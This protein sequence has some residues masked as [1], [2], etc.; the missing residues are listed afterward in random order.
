MSRYKVNGSQ[1]SFQDGSQGEV[2]ANKLGIINTVDIDD[3]E[4]SL[5]GKLYQAVI[6]DDLPEE[7]ITVAMVK[8]W[9]HQWL[10]NVYEWAGQ[11]RS[12]QMSKG[13]FMFAP[14][15]RIPH[16][17]RE[18]D[19]QCLARYTPCAG[20]SDEQTIEAIAVTHVELILIHPFRDGNGRISR[21]LAD[22]MAV[23]AGYEPLNYKAWEKR[24]DE[25]IAAVHHGLDHDYGPMKAFVAEAL[26]SV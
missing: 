10:G 15:E 22:V 9:H 8:A 26:V 20:F 5:L 14:A 16:L 18:F 13:G 1:G 24:K 4:L 11:E 2:L 7:R 25:Y 17:L 12:V 21:L 23:Q 3:V 6:Q 19:A